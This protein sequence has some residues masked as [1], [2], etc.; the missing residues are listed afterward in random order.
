MVE[1]QTIDSLDVIF[2]ILVTVI[3]GLILYSI[4]GF[5]SIPNKIGLN[6]QHIENLNNNITDITQRF[7]KLNENYLV[8]NGKVELMEKLWGTILE[9]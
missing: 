6:N 7:Y 5:W 8:L 2:G 4:I 3:G 9:K 1:P